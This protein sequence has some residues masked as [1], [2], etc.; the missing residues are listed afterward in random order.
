MCYPTLPRLL[1]NYNTKLQHC[2][3]Q[4]QERLGMGYKQLNLFEETVLREIAHEPLRTDIF[5]EFQSVARLRARFNSNQQEKLSQALIE[6][7][8]NELIEEIFEPDSQGNNQ[9][10][11]YKLTPIGRNLLAKSGGG[12]SSYN[13]G[14]ISGSNIAIGENINQ[15]LQQEDKETQQLLIKLEEALRDKDKTEVLKTLGY[16]GDKSLDLLIAIIAGGIKL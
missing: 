1:C 6:L 10:R 2:C 13:F 16:I 4:A 5:G 15:L 9:L 3:Q 8:R 12:T 7:L 14:D 11:G